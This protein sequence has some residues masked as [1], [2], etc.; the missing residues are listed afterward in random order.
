MPDWISHLL[1]GAAGLL[2]GS[3]LPFILKIR[4][5]GQSEW[6]T[7]FKQGIEERAALIARV[8]VLERRIDQQHAEHVKCLE[9][10]AELRAKIKIL[11]DR[12]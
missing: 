5:Q 8:D 7:M 1:T 3:V 6:Q 10:Q 4:Q 12:A 11:E 9:V 2:A